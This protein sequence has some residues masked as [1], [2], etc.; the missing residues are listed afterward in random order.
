VN[1]VQ[2]IVL[3]LGDRVIQEGQVFQL[4]ALY[5]RLKITKFL[6]QVVCKDERS[7][8]WDIINKLWINATNAIIGEQ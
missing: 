6:N 3:F 1:D 5:Q 8:I 2:S 4:A 7:Q